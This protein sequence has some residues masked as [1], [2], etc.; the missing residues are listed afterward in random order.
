VPHA[1]QPQDAVHSRTRGR[2]PNSQLPHAPFSLCVVPAAQPVSPVQLPQAPQVPQEQLAPHC[3]ERAFMPEPQLPHALD[4]AS[5][6]LGEQPAVVLQVPHAPQASQ[7]QL[8]PQLRDRVRSSPQAPQ[9]SGSDSLSP[10]AQT[11]S[12]AQ[13]SLSHSH[14]SRQVRVSLPHCPQLPRSSFIP[15]LQAPSSVHSALYCQLPSASHSCV[16]VPQIPQET[17]RVSP[18]EQEQS[19]GASQAFH[20]PITQR[21]MPEAHAL[22]QSRSAVRPTSGS[23][24]SQSLPATTP[25]MSESSRGSIHLPS[26]HC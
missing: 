8:A 4:S 3:R 24:S 22:A 10:A 21:S 25:S 12:S 16:R 2:V 18:D 17:L 9:L 20:E 23:P 1:P 6:S 13:T 15:G 19:V 11:P 26:R 7:A 5:F 14:V